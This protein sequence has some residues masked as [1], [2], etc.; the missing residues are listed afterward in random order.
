VKRR[1]RRLFEI[2]IEQPPVI[3]REL[4]ARLANILALAQSIAEGRVAPRHFREYAR[5]CCVEAARLTR[6]VEEIGAIIEASRA[7]ATAARDA[8]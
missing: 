3:E 8:R 4:R 7:N 1:A 6:L 5:L 2:V